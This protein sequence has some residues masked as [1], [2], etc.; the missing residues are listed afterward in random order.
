MSDGI[1]RELHDERGELL[2][3]P[4]VDAAELTPAEAT[5]RRNEVDTDDLGDLGARLEELGDSGS[6]LATH[7]SDQYPHRNPSTFGEPSSIAD[8]WE[9]YDRRSNLDCNS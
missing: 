8:Q 1:G 4:R 2:A 7:P 5:T 9:S 3:I 6:E